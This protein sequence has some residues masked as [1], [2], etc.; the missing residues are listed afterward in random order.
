MDKIEQLADLV[1]T[2]MKGYVDSAIRTAIAGIPQPRNGIDGKSVDPAE[3]M[4]NVEAQIAAAFAA[5]PQPRNGEDGKDGTSVD[6]ETV[7]ALV[8]GELAQAVLALPRPRDGVDGKSI[9]LDEVRLMVDLAIRDGL[10]RMPPPKAGADGLTVE[11]I[12]LE[13]MPDERT[14]RFAFVRDGVTVGEKF[15]TVPC[16]IDRGV[17]K[18]ELAATRGDQVTFGGTTWI[19]QRSTTDKPGTSDAWRLTVKNIT[20][21]K[22]GAPEAPTAVGPVRL[23]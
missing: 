10:A 8:K 23:K 19:A 12:E 7:R 3:L 17:W 22:G 9:Q 1:F 5:L 13:M 2:A 14:L 20:Q 6:A 11:N 16:V 15:V 4:A 21:V 18:S